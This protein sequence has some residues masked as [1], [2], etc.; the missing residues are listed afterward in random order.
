MPMRYQ[1]SEL[2][3][4]ETNKY[5]VYTND[6]TDWRGTEWIFRLPLSLTIQAS[7]VLAAM[8][9]FDPHQLHRGTLWF[10]WFYSGPSS[11][12]RFAR[13]L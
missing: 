9:C 4:T 3:F 5:V 1:N 12:K 7:T 2:S 11:R 8:A 6:L 10:G 13:R